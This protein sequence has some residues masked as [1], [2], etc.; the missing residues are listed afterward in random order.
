MIL[1]ILIILIW[2]VLV[3]CVLII[4]LDCSGTVCS[5]MDCFDMDY[6][7]MDFDYFVDIHSDPDS[8]AD[9]L[10]DTVVDQVAA[11]GIR[12]DRSVSD[13]D[14]N[15]LVDCYYS[16]LDCYNLPCL[17]PLAYCRLYHIYDK[18]V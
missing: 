6:S 17:F 13:L 11:A 12:V 5:D 14:L 10:T 8:P 7:D 4:D 1:L 15:Y 9:Y 16:R 2:I 3:R 18:T